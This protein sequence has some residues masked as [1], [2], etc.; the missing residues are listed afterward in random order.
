MTETTH[1]IKSAYWETDTRVLVQLDRDWTLEDQLPPLFLGPK[2]KPFEEL[3]QA[4]LSEYGRLA[5]YYMT[6]GDVVFIFDPEAY[7]QMNPEKEEVYVVGSFNGWDAARGDEQ[8]KLK[9][10]EIDGR[11]LFYLEVPRKKIG[12]DKEADNGEP[13]TFKLVT[14]DGFWISVAL[15]APNLIYDSQGNDNY[16]L[17]LRQSGRHLF[18]ADVS[19]DYERSGEEVLIWDDGVRRETFPLPSIGKLLEA[20]T[21][22]L[23][24]VTFV[25]GKTVFRLFAPRASQVDLYV[26]DDPGVEHSRVPLKQIGSGS[27]EATV[28]ENLEGSLYH[29]HVH[30]TN[31]DGST[32]FDPGFHILDPYAPAALSNRGPGVVLEWNHAAPVEEEAHYVPPDWHDLVILEC[33]IEDLVARSG[34][35]ESPDAPTRYRHLEAMLRDEHSYLRSLGINAIEL[36]PLQLMD[37]ESDEEYHWG[38]MTANYF[39][40]ECSYAEDPRN[41]SQIHE[42]RK[43]VKAAHEAGIA[44]ILDVVYN[45]VGEPAHLLFIDKYYYFR[46]DELQDLTNWSGCGND[47]RC[48]A[49]MA[50]RLVIDSL[51]HLVRLFDIDGF[52][53]DLAELLGREVLQDIEIALKEEKPSLILIAEPWSF[54]GHIAKD[55]RDTAYTSWNDG[56]RDFVKEYVCGQKNS[57]GLKYF[58]GGSQ[59]NFAS[60]PAQTVNYT[61]SHDDY[62]WLDSITENADN[63][64]FH[65]M[66]A[67]RRRTHLMVSLLMM[68]FG[69]PMLAEGQDFLRSKHGVKNTYQ[70]G[71]LNALDYQRLLYYTNTHRYFREWIQ[72]R[73]GPWGQLIRLPSFPG[74][75]YLKCFQSEEKSA[76]IALY[77]AD[78][79]L[80]PRQMVYAINPHLEPVEVECPELTQDRF[81]QVADS[82]RLKP[83]G[84][85]SALI[86]LKKKRKTLPALS[87]FVWVSRQ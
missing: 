36:Q 83:D 35:K 24:G 28:D 16:E 45:H 20:Y 70:R 64:G 63:N 44:V 5:H 30:G 71:D 23:M 55:L 51:L 41:A 29:Y 3:K 26:Y 73:R 62:T 1:P 54:R 67:D 17:R 75:D 40:L 47:L 43:V 52:R 79:S 66:E 77:N 18:F 6:N 76:L 87:A 42:F 2:V 33:H 15:N 11:R 74:E 32:H 12:A 25:E 82:E 49:P 14:R 65:P 21:E 19:E 72:F 53:F 22:T 34:Y 37:K 39:S 85:T 59:G 81:I 60:W 61:E 69:I 68:S 58:L 9:K 4:P 48:E 86:S 8:W 56:Y 10:G 31:R 78:H 46:L 84:L 38:Y 7:P 27:W 57:D 80:G 13:I 50:K